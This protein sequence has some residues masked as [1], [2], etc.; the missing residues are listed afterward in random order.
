MPQSINESDWKLFS[1]KLRP[2][3]LERHCERVLTGIADLSADSNKSFHERYLAIF[4]FIHDRDNEIADMFNDPRRST[5]NMQLLLIRRYGLLKDEE[6]ADF[7]DETKD[8]ISQLMG[9]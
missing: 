4:R 2:L 1:K 9:R 7:S 6:F 3:A 5:A 8:I